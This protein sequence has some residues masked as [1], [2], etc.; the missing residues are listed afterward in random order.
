[1][2]FASL[3]APIVFAYAITI[4]AWICDDAYITFRSVDN[5][6]A[7]LGPVWNTVNR[8][9]AF[10]HPLW[11]LMLTP[12]YVLTGEIYFTAIA[13]SLLLTIGA[14]LVIHR[15]VSSVLGWRAALVFL[16]LS[17]SR[18][19]V[20][21][22]TSGLETPLLFLLLALFSVRFILRDDE[23]QSGSAAQRDEDSR[24]EDQRSLLIALLLGSLAF[25][26]R[27]D[28]VLLTLPAVAYLAY[29]ARGLPWRRLAITIAVGLSPAIA[30]E[31][32]SLFYYGFP[33]PNTA[34]A[35]LDTGIARSALAKQAGWYYLNSLRWDPL[36]LSTIAA[37]LLVSIFGGLRQR[38]MAAGVVLFLLYL[39][40]IGGD[41]M[42]GRF[43]AA[44]LLICTLLLCLRLKS[45][46]AFWLT[47]S[48]ALAL[49][50]ISPSPTLLPP[51]ERN[52]GTLT[53]ARLEIAI[54]SA[55]F[56]G[57]KTRGQS[58][59]RRRGYQNGVLPIQERVLKSH[60]RTM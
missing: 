47:A 45:Q 58:I 20:D 23:Q 26:T 21:Y 9:Q 46:P 22:S 14:A 24:G 15:G 39:F 43:F 40:Y 10:T 36:T 52:L 38:L 30:W 42:S 53:I 16:L 3:I 54:A 19:F 8:V 41:F 17:C 7:G 5:L 31:L 11:L 48:S 1:M 55:N 27:P 32:F 59:S 56:M 13:L 28:S 57:S 49:M 35:K 51:A 25:T 29:Q 60:G 37:G 2:K 18:S 44:P 33:L 4:N 34:Y 50:S 6:A 12:L